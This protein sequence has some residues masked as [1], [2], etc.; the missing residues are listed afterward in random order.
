M[1]ITYEE[2]E[3]RILPEILRGIEMSLKER[4]YFEK[5][6]LN[7][8]RSQRSEKRVTNDTNFETTQ[9][10]RWMMNMTVLGVLDIL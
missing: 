3:G 8:K 6:L 7:N 10:E 1:K 9:Q 4:I 5:S 2:L